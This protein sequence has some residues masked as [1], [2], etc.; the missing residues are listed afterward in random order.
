MPNGGILTGKVY[1]RGGKVK[2]GSPVVSEGTDPRARRAKVTVLYNGVNVS[3]QLDE[4]LSSF[5]YTDVASG[6]SDTITDIILEQ[7]SGNQALLSIATT[8]LD[9]G[10]NY[11]WQTKGGYISFSRDL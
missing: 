1:N 10:E 2:T 4:Y 5:R 3:G 9:I 6:S 8:G 7:F 11:F